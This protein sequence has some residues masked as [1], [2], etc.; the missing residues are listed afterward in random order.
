MSGGSNTHDVQF[1]DS[2]PLVRWIEALLEGKDISHELHREPPQTEGPHDG[3]NAGG[4][5]G[6]LGDNL[7]GPTIPTASVIAVQRIDE[8]VTAFRQSA[9]EFLVLAGLQE[10]QAEG[11]SKHKPQTN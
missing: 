8:A 9:E 11:P 3:H 4:M 6:L 5:V 10:A 2:H 7:P 1:T